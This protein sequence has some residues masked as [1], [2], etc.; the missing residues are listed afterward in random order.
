MKCPHEHTTEESVYL[1]GNRLRTFLV[2]A[3]CGETLRTIE[4]REVTEF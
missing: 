3:D 1:V 2:C 4:D